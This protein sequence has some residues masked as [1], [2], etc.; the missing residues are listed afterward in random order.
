MPSLLPGRRAAHHSI[1]WTN[2]VT[3]ADSFATFEQRSRSPMELSPQRDGSTGRRVPPAAA[4][5]RLQS[6]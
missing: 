2:S 4:F 1:E 5:D 6:R 3:K